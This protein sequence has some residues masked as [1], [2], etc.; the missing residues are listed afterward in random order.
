MRVE[1]NDLMCVSQKRVQHRIPRSKRKRI[2][3]KWAKNPE[4]FKWVE[5][6]IV[7]EINGTLYV[8]TKAFEVLKAQATGQVD[9]M[10]ALIETR[11][12]PHP[13]FTDPIDREKIPISPPM[14]GFQFAT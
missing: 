6:H 4:N 11:A 2:R 1:I 8:S 7:Y 10:D 13:M 12:F 14:M 3:R 5:K 9:T